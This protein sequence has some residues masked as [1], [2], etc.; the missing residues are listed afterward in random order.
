MKRRADF[1]ALTACLFCSVALAAPDGWYR[2]GGYDG[3]D[4]NLAQG[5]M[6]CVQVNNAGGATNITASSAWLNGMLL[7]TGSA[8]TVVYVYWG[9]TD[10]ETNKGSWGAR[11]NFGFCIE[12]QALTTQV[13]ANSNT[14][15]Y[16][17]FYA[18][19]AVGEECWA[20]ASASFLTFAPPVLNNGPG[21]SPVGYD[22]AT[23]N[24]NLTDCQGADVTIYWGQNSIAWANTNSLGS[25][26][27]G[28]FRVLISGLSPGSGYYYRCYGTN[29]YGEDWSDIAA[30]TTRV[31]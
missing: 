5:A 1:L 13:S 26:P 7:A 30:F 31:Q 20:S 21:A 12:G 8:Q 19:N 10:G 15:Y 29:S 4:R 28:P 3:Y 11:T 27:P 23:L 24:G 18:T 22:T 9:T 6:G 14:L 17:R 25:Q 2:G 16:Y